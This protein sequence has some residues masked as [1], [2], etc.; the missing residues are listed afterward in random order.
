MKKV[1]CSLI[2]ASWKV[3]VD[4]VLMTSPGSSLFPFSLGI[5]PSYFLYSVLIWGR[6]ESL[7]FIIMSLSKKLS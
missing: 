3:K 2:S 7:V 6:T 5:L 4:S 1:R